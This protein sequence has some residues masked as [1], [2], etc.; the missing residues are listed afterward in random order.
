VL[1]QMNKAPANDSKL[2]PDAEWLGNTFPCTRHL[3]KKYQVGRYVPLILSPV[4]STASN[5]HLY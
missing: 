2:P 1:R 3:V 5:D 4:K